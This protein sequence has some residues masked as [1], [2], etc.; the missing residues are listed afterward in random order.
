MSV[1]N[2]YATVSGYVCLMVMLHSPVKAEQWL[3]DPMPAMEFAAVPFVFSSE[4]LSTAFGGAGVIKYAGQV[5]ASL[6][7]IGHYSSN[8]SYLTYFSANNYQI[9]QLDQWLFSAETYQAHFTEGVYYLPNAE[10]DEERVLAKADESF[11]KLHARFVMPIGHGRAGARASMM[12]QQEVNWDPLT[13]GVTSLKMTAFQ[14]QQQLDNHPQIPD[15]THGFEVLLNWDNRDQVRNSTQGGETSLT[16]RHGLSSGD[17]PSW[18]TWEVEQSAFVSIGSNSLF[19][20]QVLGFDAYVA[21]TLSW[22]AMDEGIAQRPPYYA[23]IGL[24]GFDRLRGYSAK[25]FTGRSAVLYSAEY[26]VQ[27]HWQPLQSWPVFSWYHVPWW[28]FVAFAET[29][30]VSDTFSASSLHQDMQWTL[31]AGVRFEVENI[32]VRAEM[33]KSRESTQFWVMVNQPF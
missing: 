19:R 30:K 25:R 24:G 2:N 13:S 12:P 21:D 18:T 7:G 8:H 22:N 6:F 17:T 9:P 32:V 29:G 31:G 4:N 27:P 1:F 28:Q 26:R 15:S 33:A 23:G 14:R 10:G 16:L 11:T 3:A 5:Q 20:Q